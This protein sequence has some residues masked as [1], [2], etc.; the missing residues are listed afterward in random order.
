MDYMLEK[1]ETDFWVVGPGLII[2]CSS[3]ACK[4]LIWVELPAIAFGGFQQ[5]GRGQTFGCCYEV[6]VLPCTAIQPSDAATIPCER[7]RHGAKEIPQTGINS[8]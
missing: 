7:R 8:N 1:M 2:P 3:F 4:G 5:V 6:A